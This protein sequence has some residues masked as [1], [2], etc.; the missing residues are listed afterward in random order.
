MPTAVAAIRSRAVRVWTRCARPET[1][2]HEFAL[3]VHVSDRRATLAQ[4]RHVLDQ[5]DAGHVTVRVIPVDYE[6]F[7]GAG[8]SMM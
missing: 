6:G 3:R 8:A 2:I 4:L 1:V 5:I 7:A